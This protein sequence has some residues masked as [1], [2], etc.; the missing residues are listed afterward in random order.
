[1]TIS[2]QPALKVAISLTLAMVKVNISRTWIMKENT[3]GG[4]RL[5]AGRVD[6]NFNGLGADKKMSPA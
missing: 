4:C 5:F 3:N 6:I 1:M 2:P